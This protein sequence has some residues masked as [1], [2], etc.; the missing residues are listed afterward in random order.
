LV[1]DRDAAIEDL[2]NAGVKRI[3]TSGGAPTAVEGRAEIKRL[4]QRA[5]GRLEIMAGGGIRETSAADVARE[6]GVR[7]IHVR[8]TRLQHTE[9]ASSAAL[10]LRRPLPADEGAWEEFDESRLRALVQSLP[11][12]S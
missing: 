2:V 5:D 4:V 7:E 6:T 9:M 3:L 1:L 11:T 8:L 12:P 10:T